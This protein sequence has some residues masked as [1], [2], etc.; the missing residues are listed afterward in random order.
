MPWDKPLDPAASLPRRLLLLSGP[1]AG[2]YR[3]LAQALDGSS[4]REVL[5]V[6]AHAIEGVTVVMPAQA[7]QHLGKHVP[8]VA[9]NG[10]ELAGFVWF[11]GENDS[12]A[13]KAAWEE[14][15]ANLEDLIHDVRGAFGGCRRGSPE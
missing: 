3:W 4:K 6:G 1:P 13:G 9:E 10:Y 11:Q 12:L 15:E 5:W 7:L 2:L 8:A 14:Y